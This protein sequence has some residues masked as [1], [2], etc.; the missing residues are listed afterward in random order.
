VARL[1]TVTASP[2]A[3]A[4]LRQTLSQRHR[5][6]AADSCSGPPRL[7]VFLR[8]GIRSGQE[9]ARGATNRWPRA[10]ST[11]PGFKEFANAYQLLVMLQG[12]TVKHDFIC[13]RAVQ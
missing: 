11:L 5:R 13:W 8:L 3:D 9:R 7:S 6:G 10:L 12:P 1:E 4:S 2:V